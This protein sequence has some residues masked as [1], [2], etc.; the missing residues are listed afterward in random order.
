MAGFGNGGFGNGNF[1]QNPPPQPSSSSSSSSSS[2]TTQGPS[3]GFNTGS[4][5]QLP[6]TQPQPQRPQQG[7]SAQ[8]QQGFSTQPQ[9]GNLAP[10]PRVAGGY[11]APAPAAGGGGSGVIPSHVV[12]AHHGSSGR[13]NYPINSRAH[14][15]QDEWIEDDRRDEF[16]EQTKQDYKAVDALM[17]EWEIPNRYRPFRKNVVNLIGTIS[18]GK[19]SFVNFFYGLYVKKVALSQLDTHW[20]IV[21]MV[22][23]DEFKSLVGPNYRYCKLTPADIMGSD[24]VESEKRLNRLILYLDPNDTLSRYEQFTSFAETFRNHRL[25]RTILINGAYLDQLNGSGPRVNRRRKN[26]ILIDSPGFGHEEKM[27]D[28]ETNLAVLQYFYHLSHLTLFFIPSTQLTSVSTQLEVLELSIL[29][30]H[31]D[32]SV[33]KLF[34]EPK[35]EEQQGGSWFP[36]ITSLLTNCVDLIKKEV[37]GTE[38]NAP[39]ILRGTSYFDNIRFVLSKIDLVPP[40]STETQLRAPNAPNEVFSELPDLSA[41]WFEFGCLLARSFK[42]LP[43]PVFDQC[44]SVSLV[45]MRNERGVRFVPDLGRL[46]SEISALDYYDSYKKRMETAIQRMCTDLQRKTG[47]TYL[48]NPWLPQQVKAYQDASIQRSKMPMNRGS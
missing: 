24:G 13:A 21:E 10:D 45:P 28:I 41:Q 31:Y 40:R 19:S 46:I 15:Y 8:P 35:R 47:G 29:Y 36:S 4:F 9:Q 44:L 11:P 14:R 48:K 32:K 20:T 38:P 12:A 1:G 37:I 5:G 33:K 22:S 7:Y 25:V 27:D 6:Q 2:S 26:T 18:S 16:M 3:G 39:N 42:I 23:E 43:C 30:A 34:A 17:T